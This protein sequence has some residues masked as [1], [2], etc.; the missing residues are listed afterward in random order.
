MPRTRRSRCGT[1]DSPLLTPHISPVPPSARVPPSPSDFSIALQKRLRIQTPQVLTS[2]SLPCTSLCPRRPVRPVTAGAPQ[3]EA[4]SVQGRTAHPCPGRSCRQPLRSRSPRPKA[5]A[6][7]LLS[8]PYSFNPPF[9]LHLLR[10]VSCIPSSLPTV[11]HFHATAVPPTRI[12]SAQQDRRCIP[13]GVGCRRREHRQGAPSAERRQDSQAPWDSVPLRLPRAPSGKGYQ[14][15][16]PRSR[17][18]SRQQAPLARADPSGP[19]APL[20]KEQ[21]LGH[22]PLP[23]ARELLGPQVHSAKELRPGIPQAPLVQLRLLRCRAHLVHKRIPPAAWEQV[24][25]RPLPLA[26]GFVRPDRLMTRQLRREAQGAEG[27][28]LRAGAAQNAAASPLDTSLVKPSARSIGLTAAPATALDRR[29]PRRIQHCPSRGVWRRA[30]PDA[31][32]RRRLW[33]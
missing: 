9:F 8:L 24:G 21:H 16:H 7:R 23:L 2:L 28:A 32:G 5:P 10:S 26:N 30:P 13:S 3:D 22:Q 29:L 11:P 6:R 25:E 33:R 31:F 4:A 1:A 20:A 14:Q 27:L 17:S 15:E 19:R 18:E 12:A